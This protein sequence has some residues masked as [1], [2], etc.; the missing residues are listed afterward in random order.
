MD[1]RLHELLDVWEERRERGEVLSAAELCALRPDWLADMPE[2]LSALSTALGQLQRFNREI[3]NA[4]ETGDGAAA[5][6][7]RLPEIENYRVDRLVGVGGMGRVF[8]GKDAHL[9]LTVAIKMLEPRSR[10]LVERDRKRLARRFVQ[11]AQTLAELNHPHIVR[12][13]AGKPRDERPYF[14]MEYMPRSLA[15]PAEQE[16]LRKAGPR[17][18]V[19]L[20]ISVAQA[21]H[22]AHSRGILHRDLKPANI[23]LDGDGQPK[24]CDFGL[25]K[26]VADADEPSRATADAMIG[27]TAAAATATAVATTA[28]APA[29]ATLTNS[30]DETPD[31]LSRPDWQPG[32]PAYMAPEQHDPSR[33][34]VDARTDVWALGVILYELLGDKKPFAGQNR[35][36]LRKTVLE[37][38][39]PRL[40]EHNRRLPRALEKVVHRCLEK[41]PAKRYPSAKAL[42]DALGGYWK[43][44]LLVMAVLIPTLVALVV[45][46][47]V[48]ETSPERAY[49]RAT[50]RL[51]ADIAA[52]K[53]VTIVDKD[54]Q[55]PPA[56]RF[57]VKGGETR[58]HMTSGEGLSIYTTSVAIVE[59]LP[60]LKGQKCKIVADIR[61]DQAH[62]QAF[63]YY[64]LFCK[65]STAPGDGAGA[66]PWF[67]GLYCGD[68][69]IPVSDAKL[70][71]FKLGLVETPGSP[72]SIVSHNL[73]NPNFRYPSV[74]EL[75]GA[76]PWRRLEFDIK[77]DQVVAGF[78]P[79]GE[80][81]YRFPATTQQDWDNVLAISGKVRPGVFPDQLPFA[82]GY[83]AFVTNGKITIRE[84]RVTP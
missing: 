62:H 84:L 58:V 14:A 26:L 44:R 61:H 46:G 17:A 42:A 22:Y 69:R 5:A 67:M 48:R 41:D 28:V 51:L 81:M 25:A 30:L 66:P 9:G 70:G 77:P 1:D 29:A 21:V 55:A 56:Y 18:I 57:R 39:P 33:G 12:V 65:A 53:T 50:D 72:F 64:G 20:M 37:I 2:L 59:F 19:K 63:G 24:V 54:N 38:K 34:P 52:G 60:T 40:R 15:D 76:T 3:Q 36:A 71:M 27:A 8:L 79:D 6:D 35:V 78:G 83:G 31:E 32:T 45:L 49:E 16:R 47:I 13:F 82:G 7:D 74:H 75:G 80:S 4:T 11:E 23:L 43:P 10:T 73:A 68:W